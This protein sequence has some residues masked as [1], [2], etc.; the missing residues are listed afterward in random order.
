MES[1]GGGDDRGGEGFSQAGNPDCG[2][3]LLGAARPV[4]PVIRSIDEYQDKDEDGR[5][6]MSEVEDI[7]VGEGPE[8][9]KVVKVDVRPSKEEV[10]KKT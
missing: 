2:P 4:S 6:D 7:S 8:I 1:Q 10:D 5:S 9:P 3:L